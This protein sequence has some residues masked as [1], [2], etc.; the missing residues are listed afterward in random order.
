MKHNAMDAQTRWTTVDSMTRQLH[1]MHCARR[2]MKSFH[3]FFRAVVA[4][5]LFTS[6]LPVAPQ[7]QTDAGLPAWLRQRIATYEQS[8]FG[9]SPNTIWSYEVAGKRVYYIVAAASGQIDQ[10]FDEDGQLICSPSAD[11]A[12]TRNMK[13]SR[14]HGPP[15][16][17]QLVW[18]DP[19]TGLTY[20]PDPLTK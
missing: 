9:R 16:R 20:E 2:F 13:C 17:M 10:L 7:S 18:Q 6:H 3:A 14:E 19:R 1:G 4:S 5:V 8:Q 12:G 11:T 15:S